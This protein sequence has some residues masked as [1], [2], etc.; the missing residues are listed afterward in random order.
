LIDK[1]PSILQALEVVISY[2]AHDCAKWDLAWISSD[3]IAGTVLKAL[4]RHFTGLRVLWK[5]NGAQRIE[6]KI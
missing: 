2:N 3:I 6:L 5:Q 1:I 4:K